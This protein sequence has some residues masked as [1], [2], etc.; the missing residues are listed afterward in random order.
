MSH[1]IVVAKATDGEVH[2][3]HVPGDRTQAKQEVLA[4]LRERRQ[5]T[6]ELGRTYGPWEID[7]T[8]VELAPPDLDSSYPPFG[9]DGKRI[10]RTR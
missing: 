10:K 8:S 4:M 9:I 1:S 2:Y 6:D 3:F 7:A 5:L